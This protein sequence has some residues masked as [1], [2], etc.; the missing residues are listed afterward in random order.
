[1]N[2]ICKS[3]K[4]CVE[5]FVTKISSFENELGAESSRNGVEISSRN[6]VDIGVIIKQLELTEL[7]K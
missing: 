6:R 7:H 3:F 2:I 4:N 5:A 1:M